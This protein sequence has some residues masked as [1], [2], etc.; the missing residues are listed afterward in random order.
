M[1]TGEYDAARKLCIDMLASPSFDC[2][3]EAFHLR[4]SDLIEYNITPP[5]LTHEKRST[6]THKSSTSKISE[7]RDH[8]QGDNDEDAYMQ[9]NSDADDKDEEDE[10]E[11]LQVPVC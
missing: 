2:I 6:S 10:D 1:N 9:S 7:P 4:Q 3:G 8:R 11:R 5:N